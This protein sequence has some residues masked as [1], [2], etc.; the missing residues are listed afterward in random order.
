M[1]YWKHCYHQR[2]VPLW[3]Y[4]RIYALPLIHIVK[5][6]NIDSGGCGKGRMSPC[7][8]HEEAARHVRSRTELGPKWALIQTSL[9]PRLY[10]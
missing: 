10:E 4:H 2:H 5:C 6:S 7:H 8:Q 1:F 9:F 3:T